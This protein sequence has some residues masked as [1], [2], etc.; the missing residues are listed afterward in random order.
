MRFAAQS[1]EGELEG[2]EC[3]CSDLKQVRKKEFLYVLW[4][5]AVFAPTETGSVFQE[6]TVELGFSLS[7]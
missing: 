4:Q 7:L 2:S 1:A 5:K 6:V 3:M